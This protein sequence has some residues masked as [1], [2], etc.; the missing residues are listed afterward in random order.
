MQASF[1]SFKRRVAFPFHLNC[2]VFFSDTHAL[3]EVIEPGSPTSIV[4]VGRILE[5]EDLPYY[6]PCTVV[7]EDK[8]TYD[9]ILLFSGMS[10]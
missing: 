8:Q 2:I 10:S 1:V 5:K 9:C 4:A 6:A 3:V 7:W